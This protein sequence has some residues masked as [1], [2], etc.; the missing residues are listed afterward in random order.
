MPPLIAVLGDASDEVGDAARRALLLVTRQDLGRDARRWSEWWSKNGS[1]HRIEW[2][3]D[4]LMHDVPGIRRAAGDELKQ[5]TKEYF[6]YYD[7]L[8]KKER[9]RAQARYRE[10]WE[11]EGRAKFA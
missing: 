11:R 7:D 8:P 9:E 5:L 6:G 2:L 10:C 4:A 1:R 3:V